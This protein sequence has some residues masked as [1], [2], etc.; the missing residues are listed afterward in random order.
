MTKKIQHDMSI[1]QTIFNKYMPEDSALRRTL[2]EKDLNVGIGAPTLESFD[3]K[4]TNLCYAIRLYQAVYDTIISYILAECMTREGRVALIREQGQKVPSLL[5][6]QYIFYAVNREPFSR[7]GRGRFHWFKAL[8]YVLEDAF[9]G[10]H[11]W[12]N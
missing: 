6:L 3:C 5:L 1:R 2:Q 4:H 9:D 12:M 10:I 7:Q 8:K 11:G